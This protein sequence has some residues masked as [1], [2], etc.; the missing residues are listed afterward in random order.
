MQ[1]KHKQTERKKSGYFLLVNENKHMIKGKFGVATCKTKK[2]SW[3]N[4]CVQINAACF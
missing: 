3:E 4:M 2:D 1:K